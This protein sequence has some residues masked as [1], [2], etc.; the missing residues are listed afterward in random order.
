MITQTETRRVE[1]R[2]KSWEWQRMRKPIRHIKI[3]TIVYKCHTALYWAMLNVHT[4][5]TSQGS[6]K[7]KDVL[8]I[9]NTSWKSR[10]AILRRS[11]GLFSHFLLLFI[12]VFC[13][14]CN[15]LR[16][17]YNCFA[18]FRFV[19]VFCSAL[20]CSLL[21]LSRI[22]LKFDEFFDAFL[23]CFLYCFQQL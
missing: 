1:K 13:F 19:S 3:L 23:W 7:C 22:L 9:W 15:K 11:Y 14:K 20:L 4:A 16:S 8:V 17:L 12:V 6:L 10:V 5:H 18:Y 2:H 21:I